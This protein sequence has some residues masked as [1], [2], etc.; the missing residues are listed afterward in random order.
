MREGVV[1]AAAVVV[2][3]I[4]RRAPVMKVPSAASAA[5]PSRARPVAL[6]VVIRVA[7][8]EVVVAVTATSTAPGVVALAPSPPHG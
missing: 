5:P 6:A 7:H 8:R 2:V 1:Y 4:A 3:V